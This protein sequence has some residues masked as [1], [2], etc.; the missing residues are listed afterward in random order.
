MKVRKLLT[1]VASLAPHD[2]EGQSLRQRRFD[3]ARVDHISFAGPFVHVLLTRGDT[4]ES[5]EAAVPREQSREMALK[6]AED[7]YL[8]ARVARLFADDYSI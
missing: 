2:L 3:P 1:L 8:R 5:I 6:P 4:G 7:V